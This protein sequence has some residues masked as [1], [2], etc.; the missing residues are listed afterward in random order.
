MARKQKVQTEAEVDI[1]ALEAA[2]AD[3]TVDEVLDDMESIEDAVSE[4]ERSE[5]LESQDGDEEATTEEV[6][7][8]KKRGRAA[9]ES[10]S[11]AIEHYVDGAEIDTLGMV[12]EDYLAHVD[13][14]AKKV[15]EK[16]A[17]IFAAAYGDKK[18][19]VYTRDALDYLT[20]AGCGVATA[21]DLYNMFRDETVGAKAY[22]EGT[23]RSQAQQQMDAL[24]TTGICKR[25]GKQIVL[26]EES[27]LYKKLK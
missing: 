4:E 12:R 13:G 10:T 9:F 20:N 25:D 2:L 26:R 15:Q 11:A 8:T 6:A 24:V 23:S 21:T 27:E 16:I 1:D 18:L 14:R 5:V 17:N 19:S 3:E 22:S 7:E